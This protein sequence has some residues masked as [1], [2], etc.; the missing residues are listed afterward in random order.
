MWKITGYHNGGFV[1]EYIDME[2]KVKALEIAKP[3]LMG[4][5]PSKIKRY[6]VH[7]ECICPDPVMK[8]EV[9]CSCGGQI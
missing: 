3:L 2:D 8:E 7:L 6:S 4:M 9:C 1:V 5:A